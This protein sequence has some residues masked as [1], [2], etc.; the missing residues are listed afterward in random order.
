MIE[1]IQFL[2]SLS[3]NNYSSIMQQ[4]NEIAEFERNLGRK[5][6]KDFMAYCGYYHAASS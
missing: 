1:K 5:R 3:R 6:F 4:K 2:I